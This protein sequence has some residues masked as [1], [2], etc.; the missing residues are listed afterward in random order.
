MGSILGT[1]QGLLAGMF[2]MAGIMKLVRSKAQLAEKMAWVESFEP[3][4][5][6][7][8]ASLEIL[9][10]LGLVLPRITGILPLLTP[11]AAAGLGMM[12]AGAFVTHA[13]R[14][15]YPM[16]GV[17]G[18]LFLMAAFLAYGRFQLVPL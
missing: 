11:L 16:L 13:K 3:G 9:G 1:L 10:A 6:R 14:G 7:L 12:M 8:I 17:T 4:T 18:V 2:L 15:E 5:I